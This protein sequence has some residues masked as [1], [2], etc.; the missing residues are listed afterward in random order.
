MTEFLLFTRQLLTRNSVFLT[1]DGAQSGTEMGNANPSAKGQKPT[2]CNPL[3]TADKVQHNNDLNSKQA[4]VQPTQTYI[5][6]E[7]GGTEERY[8]P[9]NM[10]NNN[11]CKP[12]R[13]SERSSPVPMTTAGKPKPTK[14]IY[15]SR[16]NSKSAT[17]VLGRKPGLRDSPKVGY[18]SHTSNADQ[19]RSN[20]S[21]SL[22]DSQA[23]DIMI[24]YSHSDK[25]I[26]LRLK[27][28]LE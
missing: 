9:S 4:Q 27:G 14:D 7:N 20:S 1:G 15:D 17:P 8:K 21:N 19:H 24:S 6:G 5:E 11:G 22:K 12:V 28:T 2:S 10:S 18:S 25:E 13:T 26:M 16:P 3:V 23:K